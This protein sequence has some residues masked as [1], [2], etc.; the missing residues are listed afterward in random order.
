MVVRRAISF[1]IGKVERIGGDWYMKDIEARKESEMGLVTRSVC[2][3]S[4]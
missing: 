3:G 2:Y 4:E 1:L